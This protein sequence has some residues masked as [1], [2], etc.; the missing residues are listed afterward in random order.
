METQ[1]LKNIILKELPT[2]IQRDSAFRE[3]ILSISRFEFADKAETENRIAQLDHSMEQCNQQHLILTKMISALEKLEQRFDQNI[4]EDRQRWVENQ[5][6]WAE[7]QKLWAETLKRLDGLEQRFDGLEQR[8]DGL[9]QRFDGLEQRFDGLEQRFDGLEQRFDGLEQRFEQKI[10]EDR[11]KWA[12][13]EKRLDSLEQRLDQKIEEDRQKW[14]ENEK[15]LDNLEQRLEQ[16]IDKVFSKV[17]QKL[18]AI[19][20]R[21]GIQSEASF[22]NALA[23]IL[24]NFEDVKVIHVDEH[25]EQ[26]IVFGYPEEVELDI[27]IKNGVLM[28][29]E[30]KSSVEKLHIAIFEKKVHFYEQKHRQKA[31][32]KIVISPQV[33]EKAMSFAKQLGINVYTYAQDV[34][35]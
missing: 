24:Q 27:I 29:A 1:Q 12:E 3:A 35:L 18:G 34:D 17:D 25:D 22:R 33:D 11:Q 7:N 30:M 23:G 20:A 16:K 31:S 10:E 2:L 6:L 28:I 26:G 15:Q 8:F 19:G 4:K 13:N 21:W 5:R 9:E 14:A 32:K